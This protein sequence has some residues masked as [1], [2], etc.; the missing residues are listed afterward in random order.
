MDQKNLEYFCTSKKLNRQQARWSLHLSHFNF[1]LHHRVNTQV[2]TYTQIPIHAQISAY[3]Q[4]P[5]LFQ[6]HV[7]LQ[8]S[9]HLC[10]GQAPLPVTIPITPML[11]QDTNYFHKPSNISRSSSKAAAFD[12]LAPGI[13]TTASQVYWKGYSPSTVPIQSL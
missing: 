7:L 4:L 8:P 11:G 2:R 10:R 12:I 9:I 5:T 6:P 13:L 3:F 1:T